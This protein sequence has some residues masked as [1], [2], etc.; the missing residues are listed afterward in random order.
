MEAVLSKPSGFTDQ[1]T[2]LG[3][4]LRKW[5]SVQSSGYAQEVHGQVSAAATEDTRQIAF[6]FAIIA[7]A[8][9]LAQVDGVVSK[10][11]YWAFREVFPMQASEDTKIR[12]LFLMAMNEQ[13]QP[14]QYVRQIVRL[15]PG[16]IS[17]YREIVNRLLKVATADSGLSAGQMDYMQR[18]ALKLGLSRRE[19]KKMAD[20]FSAPR[21]TD[22]YAVLGI[23]RTA[24]A[25][26]LKAAHRE[27][28]RAHHPDRF[29][30]QGASTETLEMLAARM[31]EINAAYDEV[32]R[33][34]PKKG[35]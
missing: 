17:L 26:E 31:A 14:D 30:S 27:L 11:S 9:K 21:Q 28:V 22:P 4:C 35:A 20:S 19:W 6:T 3:Q 23:S 18:V 2:F 33:M 10:Q 12:S 1:L 32:R 8:A 34:R 15:F 5:W 25:A 24:D 7:L 29:A 13:S 16:R